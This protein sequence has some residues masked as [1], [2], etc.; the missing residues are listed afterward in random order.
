MRTQRTNYKMVTVIIGIIAI[1]LAGCVQ[2]EPSASQVDTSNQDAYEMSAYYHHDTNVVEPQT[3]DIFNQDSY[4]EPA[5]YK[6][7]YYH[8]TNVAEPQ[9][10]DIFNQDS[11]E[12]PAYYKYAYYHDSNV[13]ESQVAN[14]SD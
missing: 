13:T 8:D 3:I 4:E 5:Y 6:Y 1:L 9:T 10:I 12:M 14:A 7:A 11:Y 2:V